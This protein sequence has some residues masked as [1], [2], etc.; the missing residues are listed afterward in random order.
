MP[1]QK[2]RPVQKSAP[3]LMKIDLSRI[4][5]CGVHDFK[6]AIINLSNDMSNISFKKSVYP[7]PLYT[8]P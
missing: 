3:G 1:S 6:N 5:I 7:L 8:E 4:S 2:L